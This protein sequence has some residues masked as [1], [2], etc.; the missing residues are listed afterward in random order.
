M[1]HWRNYKN[2]LE[3]LEDPNGIISESLVGVWIEQ[4]L[5]NERSED[6]IPMPPGF[7]TEEKVDIWKRLKLKVSDDNIKK[8][9]EEIWI[10]WTYNL[11][12][13][14]RRLY[15]SNSSTTGYSSMTVSSVTSPA[16][17]MFNSRIPVSSRTSRSTPISTDDVITQYF[18]AEI[19]P[20]KESED[21]CGTFTYA[22]KQSGKYVCL[23][24]DCRVPYS[25]VHRTRTP[26]V[27]LQTLRYHARKHHSI[28]F[29][30][31][32]KTAFLSEALSCQQCGKKFSRQQ[33]LRSHVEK[34]HNNPVTS[35]AGLADLT[36]HAGDGGSPLYTE[37]RLE[38]LYS[39]RNGDQ[40][41]NMAVEDI[42]MDFS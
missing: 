33:T 29:N 9:I 12:N 31:K 1:F 21:P 26:A 19:F 3:Y 30:A 5:E 6:S 8:N 35:P 36:Q 37:T 39:Q 11:N 25:R 28:H 13:E 38:Q 24:G 40:V 27:T 4:L 32:K 42:E 2:L 15:S 18:S 17:S 20:D 34:I 16:D 23:T 14:E 41:E 22:L 7:L 10:R